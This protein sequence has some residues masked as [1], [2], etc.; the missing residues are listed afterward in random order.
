MIIKHYKKI[1]A[2][3]L[4]IVALV[5]V[6][7]YQA[8][9]YPGAV[10]DAFTVASS[11]PGRLKLVFFD[12]GQGDAALIITPDG[13]DILVD[14]GPDN[15]VV[16]KLGEYLPYTDRKIEYIIL[17][18]PHADH[19][20]GL[21]ETLKRYEVGRILMTGVVYGTAEYEKFI[22]SATEKNIPIDIIDGPETL[23]IGDVDLIILAPQVSWQGRTIA[24]LNNSS[25]AF[26]L[27]YG[28]TSALYTGDLETEESLLGQSS[29]TLAAEVLKVG[30]HGS[31]NANDRK[32]LTAVLPRFAIISVGAGNT[33]GL[34]SYRTIF[35]LKQL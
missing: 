10:L 23:A 14:G 6:R 12:V 3:L 17:T 21:V 1:L 11:T 29:S 31:G 33:Y 30:H 2:A 16:Q 25:I 34:P 19:L 28:S 15:K 22:R 18:H 26:K 32:F 24:N 7:L 20:V 4:I 9:V 27:V 35:Y 5:V 8:P 13:Q